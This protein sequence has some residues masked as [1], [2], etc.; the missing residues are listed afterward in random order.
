MT[1][2]AERTAAIVGLGQIGGSIGLDLVSTRAVQKVIGIDVDGETVSRA[3]GIGAVDCTM[4]LNDALAE[5][6][7][8]VLATPI[9]R[10][11]EQVPDLLRATPRA[12]LVTDVAS[13]KMP[14]MQSALSVVENTSFVGGHPISGEEG[15]G[16]DSS[17][18]GRFRDKTWVLT[19][20]EQT[21]QDAL[22]LARQ[23]VE[24]LGANSLEMSAEEHDKVLAYTSHLPYAIAVALIRGG[25]TAAEEHSDLCS[26]KGGSFLSATRVAASEVG[27]TLNMWAYN[28]KNVIQSIDLY[29]D[30]LRELQALLRL[31]E[32]QRLSALIETGREVACRQAEGPATGNSSNL[33]GI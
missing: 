9:D 28:R 21:S 13:V 22:D 30:S 14:V 1:E 4:D 8:V 7:I 31:E 19:S 12:T 32:Y 17:A 2:L 3:L 20:S 33:T 23:L 15:S 25:L 6:D 11:C 26:L 10:V 29:I 5:A 16:I 18:V 27:L 24:S